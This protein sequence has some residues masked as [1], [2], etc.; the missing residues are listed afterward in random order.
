MEAADKLM[1]QTM[2][3]RAI[4]GLEKSNEAVTVDTAKIEVGVDRKVDEFLAKIDTGKLL[5][6]FSTAID[7]RL[8]SIERD[9]KT[10]KDYLEVL[11][12]KTGPVQLEQSIRQLWDK[13]NECTVAI[14]TMKNDFQKNFLDRLITK[15]DDSDLKDL[16]IQ[17]NLKISDIM[18]EFHV[19]QTRAYD[20]VN[21][22]VSDIRIRSKL[23]DFY[24]K[25]INQKGKI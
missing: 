15:I 21:G 14:Q 12:Q 22:K 17:S 3:R 7:S 5:K 24:L 11:H 2:I 8:G 9:V 20:Y 6:I 4:E 1:V 16:Y 23:R 19:E 13:Y 25:A 10:Q 18:K